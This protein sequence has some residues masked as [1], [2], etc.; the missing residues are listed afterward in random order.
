MFKS[1][2]TQGVRLELP[3]PCSLQRGELCQARRDEASSGEKQ[4]ESRSSW[5]QLNACIKAGP[6]Q[7]TAKTWKIPWTSEA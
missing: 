4:G 5:D 1:G 7:C 6:R 2:P 3:T